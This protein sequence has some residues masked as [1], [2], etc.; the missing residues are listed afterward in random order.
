MPKLARNIFLLTIAVISVSAMNLRAQC[1]ISVRLRPEVTKVD[2]SVTHG[3]LIDIERRQSFWSSSRESK[4]QFEQ[5]P[6]GD[7]QFVVARDGFMTTSGTVKVSCGVTAEQRQT[8][9]WVNQC[10]GNEADTL[11]SGA[12]KTEIIDPNPNRFTV[13]GRVEFV[14]REIRG[15]KL[16][17]LGDVKRLP[18]PGSSPI[19]KQISGGVLNGKASSLPQP[20]YPPAAREVGASGAVSVQVLINETGDVVSASAVSGHQL[21]RA[22]AVEAARAAKFPVTRL[23]GQAVKV[24]GVITYNF[25]P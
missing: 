17:D 4:L 10:L 20:V 13:M 16:G 11:P 3:A 19:P 18:T 7:Y 21:L 22:A 9:V 1:S 6:N 12:V 25:T 15:D 24:S 23:S 2:S 8:Y 14:C 5:I